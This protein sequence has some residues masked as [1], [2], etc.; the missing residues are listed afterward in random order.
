LYKYVEFVTYK[1]QIFNVITT[2]RKKTI[3]WAAP[4]TE[5]ID[6]QIPF[7]LPSRV[8]QDQP[9]LAML[10]DDFPNNPVYMDTSEIRLP[11]ET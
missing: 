9:C 10:F 7:G 4:L 3:G 1:H 6:L 5:I 11:D 2:I 8:N